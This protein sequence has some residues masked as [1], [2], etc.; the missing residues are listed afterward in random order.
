MR[1]FI[2]NNIIKN[3][4]DLVNP[5]CGLHCIKVKDIS[6]RA[7]DQTII[8][9]VN[10]HIHCGK[11][12]VIIGRNGAGKSTLIKAILGEVKHT[13]KVE[14][15]DLKNR[16]MEDLRI[17]YVPQH[18]NIEKNT[19]VSVYDMFAGYISNSPVFFKKNKKVY[20]FIREQLSIFDAA[21]LIDKRACDLSGGELQR[22]LL[23]IAITPIP[24]LL[25]LDEPVSGID[26]NGME[27][28][29]ENIQRLKENYDL[30]MIVVSHDFEFV[31]RYADHVI[32]LDK[33]I[34]KE[35]S[36]E[37]VRDSLDFQKV[38]GRGYDEYIL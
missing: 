36:F 33:T 11:I 21:D 26:R 14:F 2:P 6:V 34:L 10:L 18:I 19:P 38:F 15:T 9:N 8:E 37:E 4:N 35:G 23:A 1:T 7:G 25:L 24:N 28:F 16:T 12:T 3:S 13:G 30:A 22:V 20:N 29:Y 5:A 17:G 32:L 27:L 31:K